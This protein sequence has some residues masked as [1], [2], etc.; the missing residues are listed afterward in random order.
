MAVSR[1]LKR[2]GKRERF[3]RAKLQ[4]SIERAA[5]DAGISPSRRRELALDLVD[6][7]LDNMKKRSSMSAVEL[8]ERVLSRL[9]RQARSVASAWRSFDR[10]RK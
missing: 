1:V 8:R 10:K 3:S 9:D 7:V 4:R 5:K 2:S 6:S